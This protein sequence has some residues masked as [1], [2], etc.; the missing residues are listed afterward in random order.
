M[1]SSFLIDCETSGITISKRFKYERA[2]VE[3]ACHH[4]GYIIQVR[5]DNLQRE[6]TCLM[7]YDV[8]TYT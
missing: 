2:C 8:H 6:R 7:T 1:N 4:A 3:Y 5:Y